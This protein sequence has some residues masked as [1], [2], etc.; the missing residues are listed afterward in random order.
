MRTTRES[1]SRFQEFYPEEIVLLINMFEEMP[2]GMHKLPELRYLVRRLDGT[3]HPIYP[4]AP[5]VAWTTEGYIE[6]MESGFNN[7]SAAYVHRL[8]IH[9]KAHFLWEHQFDDRLKD[10]WAQN[11]GT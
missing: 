9:E 4:E 1:A 8:I 7:F 10:D 2:R 11:D 5:A 6:F 3:P